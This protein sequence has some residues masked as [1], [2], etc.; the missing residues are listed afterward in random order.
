VALAEG[1]ICI[2]AGIAEIRT[3]KTASFIEGVD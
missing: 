3:G 2:V 1:I